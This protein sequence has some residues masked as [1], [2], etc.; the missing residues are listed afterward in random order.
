M[1]LKVW[2]ARIEITLVELFRDGFLRSEK[3]SLG[4]WV[5]HDEPPE[6]VIET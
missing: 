3:G 2:W 5:A 4:T 6:R 1:G